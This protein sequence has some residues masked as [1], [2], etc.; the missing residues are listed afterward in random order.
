MVRFDTIQ[1]RQVRRWI[2]RDL[3]W[4]FWHAST[5]RSQAWHDR[6]GRG[7][8]KQT[9]GIFDPGGGLPV[10]GLILLLLSGALGACATPP[11]SSPFEP[12]L[13]DGL[14]TASAER[15][16]ADDLFTLSDAMRHYMNVDIAREV[17][18][19][20]LPRGLVKALSRHDRIMLD[21]AHRRSD[22]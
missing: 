19:D 4:S 7:A 3:R 21:Y 8:V 2:Y 14:F 10:R 15:V 11:A 5:L 16:S 9:R 13:E 17:H 22:L 20:G 12:Y 1:A 6:L 18:S